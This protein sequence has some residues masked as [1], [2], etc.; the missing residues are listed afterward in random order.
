VSAR[1]VGSDCCGDRYECDATVRCPCGCGWCYCSSCFEAHAARIVRAGGGTRQNPL[2]I[3]GPQA[4]EP[5]EG[6]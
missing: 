1:K 5:K 6:T 3:K 4:P 2:R